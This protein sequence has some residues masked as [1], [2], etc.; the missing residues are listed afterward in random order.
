MPAGER[1]ASGLLLS[2]SG[3]VLG[4]LASVGGAM[5]SVEWASSTQLPTT[6]PEPYAVGSRLNTYAGNGIGIGIDA[7]NR[8]LP[9][10]WGW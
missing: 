5:T 6:L 4:T 9:V 8:N 2:S 10:V 1:L 7:S 3:Y